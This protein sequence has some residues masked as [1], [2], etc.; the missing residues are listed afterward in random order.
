LEAREAGFGASFAAA[1]PRKRLR[2]ASWAAFERL[3]GSCRSLEWGDTWAD[4][5]VR[6]L[7]RNGGELRGLGFEAGATKT[8]AGS[9]RGRFRALPPK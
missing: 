6:L 9:L 4:G 2:G 8:P 1:G 7:R 3:L 5:G